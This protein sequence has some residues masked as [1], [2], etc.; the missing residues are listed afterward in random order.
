MK[1]GNDSRRVVKDKQL[2]ASKRERE[3]KM[4]RPIRT[5]T[6]HSQLAVLTLGF[7]YSRLHLRESC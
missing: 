2:K 1:S 5:T 3:Q 7:P 6:S 4:A